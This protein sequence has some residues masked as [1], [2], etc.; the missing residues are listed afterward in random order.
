M[1]NTL[2]QIGLSD[3]MPYVAV[4]RQG[5]IQ[6]FLGISSRSCRIQRE[7][8]EGRRAKSDIWISRVG[9]VSLL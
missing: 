2:C 5:Q 3:K 1:I 9:V 4:G 8:I 7:M 6:Y